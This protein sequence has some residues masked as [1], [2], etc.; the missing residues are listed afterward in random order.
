MINKTVTWSVYDL[1]SLGGSGYMVDK[2]ANMV[3]QI[4]DIREPDIKIVVIERY[5][6]SITME[7]KAKDIGEVCDR[8]K[9]GNYIIYIST[10]VGLEK[11][12]NEEA[13]KRE[14]EMLEGL[15]FVDVSEII[16]CQTNI[17]RGFIYPNA[18]GRKILNRFYMDNINDCLEEL[19]KIRKEVNSCIEKLC[20]IAGRDK[21][22]AMGRNYK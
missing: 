5:E 2:I 9:D 10:W 8:Y 16:Q 17:S 15:G 3:H 11:F 14:A 20:E 4:E 7:E 19:E 13:I 1:K 22:E 12:G 18:L 6:Y 21:R